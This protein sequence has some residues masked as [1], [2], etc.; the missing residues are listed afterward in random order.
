M[1]ERYAE[2]RVI[3]SERTTIKYFYLSILGLITIFVLFVAVWLS[4]FL[5]RQ[6]SRPIEAL[7]QATAEVSSGHLDYRVD[8]PASDELAGLVLTRGIG[9][10]GLLLGGH[11][12]TTF[13][14]TTRARAMPA[15]GIVRRYQGYDAS[16]AS[17]RSSLGVSE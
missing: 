7:V 4:L 8:A 11:Q 1:E 10:H 17:T 5:S 9:G 16:F 12:K 14:T 2:Y 3:E 13:R 15:S 6:I